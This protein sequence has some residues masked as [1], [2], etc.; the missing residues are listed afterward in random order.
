MIA[1]GREGNGQDGYQGIGF[2][3]VLYIRVVCESWVVV[4]FPPFLCYGLV[5]RLAFFL[6]L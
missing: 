3:C 1:G 2:L 5:E 4:Y 6:A